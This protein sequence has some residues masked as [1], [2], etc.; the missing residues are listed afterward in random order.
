MPRFLHLVSN[1]LNIFMYCCSGYQTAISGVHV[2]AGCRQSIPSSNIDNCARVSDT[3][4]VSAFG[5]T[6]LPRSKRFE[7]RQRPS[8]SNHSS[9]MR[10]PRRPRKT[11]KWPSHCTRVVHVCLVDGV[12]GFSFLCSCLQCGNL[13]RSRLEIEVLGSVIG[14][15]TD[16]SAFV[17]P[18][19]NFQIG[20]SDPAGHFFQSEEPFFT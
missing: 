4:P 19:H 10:S 16:D 7:N 5:Q 3:V 11:N 20:N 15:A 14:A 9:L 17:A 2:R 6:N 8:P 13:L 18:L 12:A 1:V